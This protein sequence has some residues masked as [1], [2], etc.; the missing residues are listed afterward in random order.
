MFN[1][2]LRTTKL[3][4]TSTRGLYHTLVVLSTSFGE[5]YYF[6]EKEGLRGIVSAQA[7]EKKPRRRR[8]EVERREAFFMQH[9]NTIISHL[10]ITCKDKSVQ[11][12]KNL[13]FPQKNVMNFL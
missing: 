12:F 13:L 4:V 11:N 1:N 10:N 3:V 8:S 7:S 5:F 2:H 6:V 9:N